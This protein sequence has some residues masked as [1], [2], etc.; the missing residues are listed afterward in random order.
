MIHGQSPPI[1]LPDELP[2]AR[3]IAEASLATSDPE[4]LPETGP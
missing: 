4:G 2:C 1:A 3:T